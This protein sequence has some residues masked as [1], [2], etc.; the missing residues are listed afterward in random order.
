MKKLEFNKKGEVW[1]G[2]M[3][4]YS[5]ERVFKNSMK[6]KEF[7]EAY[8]KE[9]ARLDLVRQFRELRKK[10]RLTQKALADKASMP[11]SVIA[12]FEAGDYRVSLNTLARMAHAIGKRIALV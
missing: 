7:R 11:Q 9:T 3:K 4:F 1:I 6:D 12:R 5:T 2:D 10:K 8:E